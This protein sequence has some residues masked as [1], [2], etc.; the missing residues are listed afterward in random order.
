MHPRYAR[1]WLEQQAVAGL[2]EVDDA[3][4]A[5][6]ARRFTL[7]DEHAAVLA[8]PDSL[9]YFAPFARMIGGRRRAAAG[10]ARRLPHRRRRRLERVRRRDAHRRRPTPTGR[11]TSHRSAASGCRRCPTCTRALARRRPGRRRRLRRGLVVDRHGAGLPGA[12]VDG[13]DVDA[14]SVDAA[15]RARRVVR[16]R[17]PGALPPRR[18]RDA[19]TDDG[20]Y[21]LVTAFE[22]IHD[23]PDPVGVLAAMRAAGRA[24]AARVLV[25]DER[26]AEAFT[27]AGRPGRAADVRHLACWSACPTACPRRRRSA[28]GTVMRPTTLRGY[29]RDAGFADV[30]VLPDRARHVPLLPAAS[31]DAGG[32]R[33]MI[34][35]LAAWQ[36]MKALVDELRER[37]GARARRAAREAARAKHTD[38]GKLLVR[39]RVDRLLDPGSPF[40]EL[41]PL[42][43]YRHVRR[44]A[45]T[46]PSQRRHR[47][48]HRPGQRPRV[49]GRRQRRD[50]QGRHL[51]PDDGQE[52]PARAGGRPGQPAALHLPRRLRR[53]VPADAG[54]GVPRPEHFGRIFFNQANLS[55]RGHPADRRG[56][57]LVHRRRRLR[58]GDVRRDR[59]RPRPG[60]DL[61]RRPAAGEGRDRRG[62]HRRGAR[63]RRR[64]RPHVRRRRPPRRGRRARAGDRARRSSAPCRG[65]DGAPRSSRSRAEEPHEDPHDALRR[66]AR[67]TPARRTTCA[68]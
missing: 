13:Y 17:R 54:R 9:A 28:T 49:R 26:V 7:A 67:P 30:E 16:R 15:R 62:R 38:R 53:R 47:H 42:A 66:G 8:D 19:P 18:R 22:C 2:L 64:A 29:A 57:G 48:R 51:L 63:R 4:A 12:R 35:N 68:R 27:G 37:L 46:T 1:E 61:P 21:D 11:C 14:A 34:A 45:T 40:L 10:A 60:H 36:E 55:A 41:S 50:R 20:G 24:P 31:A 3:G 6:D 58:P 5:A 25:M 52:A 32:P 59:D 65:A 56:D 44:P 33:L 23:M 43:A 39:D